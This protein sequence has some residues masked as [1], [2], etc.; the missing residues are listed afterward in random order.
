[1]KTTPPPPRTPRVRLCALLASLVL[2]ACTD[3]PDDLLASAKAYLDHH[4]SKAAIIQAKNALQMAPQSPE[5]R[6]V[7]GSALLESG[8]LSGAEAELRKSLELKHPGDRVI[9][10]L[11]K[12][13]LAQGQS[14]KAIDAFSQ[15]TLEHASAQ[16]SLQLTLSAAYADQGQS[17]Q[18]Q[19]AL[20]ASLKAEPGY[21]PALLERARQMAAERDYGPA[22]ALVDEVLGK[23]PENPSAWNLKGDILWHAQGK[24]QEAA[25][26][27]RTA[28]RIKPDYV[29]SH[30]SLTNILLQEGNLAEAATQLEHLQKISANHPQVHYL[31]AQLA[32]QKNDYKQAHTLAQQ[33]LKAAPRNVQALQ[34]AGAVALQLGELK[35]AEG[36]LSAALEASPVLTLARRLLVMTYLRSG[37][38][39]KAVETLQPGLSRESIDP[40]LIPLAGE[41]YLQAGD[42]NKAGAYFAKASQLAPKD[43][44]RK[45]AL[46]LVHLR[47]GMV[48]TALEELRH[49]AVTDT[50]TTA[51]LAL[52]NAHLKRQELDKALKAIDGL[53]RK[54]PTLPVAAHLRARVLL[55][56][57]NRSGA[58][59]SLEHALTLDPLYFPAIAGLAGMDL[60]DKK[61]EAARQ[62]FESLLK[63]DPGNKQALLALAELAGRT[64]A[65]TAE[66]AKLIGNA[67]QANPSDAEIRLLL[68][69]FYIHNKDIKGASSAAQNAATAF[70]DNPRLIDALGRTQQ[71][72][73]DFNQA[74]ASYTRL[75][76]L[77][78]DSPLPLMGLAQAHWAARDAAAASNQLR[79]ALTL[80]PDFLD[81]QRALIALQV[82]GRRF[83]DAIT[84]AR[85]VQR[86][87]PK[88]GVG[89]ILEGD[90]HAADKKWDAAAAAYRTGLQGAGST[91][92]AV[93][94]HT[95]LR[96]SAPPS[97]AERFSTTWQKDHPQDAA[98][99]LYLAD[100][101][102]ARA[103]LAT[104]EKHYG[105]VARLQPDNATAFNNLAWVS[106]KLK[107]DGAMAYAEKA[108]ALAPNQ[109]TFL[110]TLAMLRSEKGNYAKALEL[111]NRALALEPQNALFRLNLAKIHLRGGHA[112]LAKAELHALS[113]LGEKFPA[114]LEVTA[115][116]KG[117]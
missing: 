98:F 19:S 93:K 116:L 85:T 64:G 90:V 21:P 7:L 18:A 51:D 10:Q 9:P 76:A 114:Q 69:N 56:Q 91:A 73:G 48:D 70:P 42:L 84:I 86:Q 80:Q 35:K 27:Y 41:V 104:A 65:S 68:I 47:S 109:A 96:A 113:Q 67:V 75:A 106:A 81:A 44:K 112:D 30:A 6:F 13:L 22:L 4:D 117:L 37:Q 71:A 87:R 52:I 115:L 63:K 72:S 20:D 110:D 33:F 78:P 60:T 36:H 25:V 45:T 62:R 111:Q 79:K 8:D 1:M 23:D 77:V 28:T 83:P 3:Q 95:V 31:G 49:I 88:D 105:T 24:L 57:Q 58:R 97:E 108:V 92:V 102:L 14:R 89:F 29:V 34:L 100:S 61:P 53:E 40:G 103:D 43:G 46:A 50:D 26:A 66:V 38:I 55:A 74:I 11:A 16:A 59:A 101:A 39:N 12:V 99:L 32:F 82:E 15:T 5:A 17:A 94:L 54:Q 2:V 107:R